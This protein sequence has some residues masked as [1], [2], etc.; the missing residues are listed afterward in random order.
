MEPEMQAE[1]MKRAETSLLNIV[2]VVWIKKAERMC[3]FEP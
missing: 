2:I 3:E 1:A